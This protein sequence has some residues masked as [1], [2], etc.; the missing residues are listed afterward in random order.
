MHEREDCVM[1]EHDQLATQFEVERSRLWAVAYRM[2]GSP[3]EAEDA[4]QECWLHLIR[5]DISGVEHLSKWLTTVVARIC[6]DMLRSRAARP[7][8]SL[9]ASEHEIIETFEGSVDPEQDV[10]LADTIGLALLVVL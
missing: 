1:G 10:L 3:P 8:E 2:L 4:V 9:E 7:E 5:S 6:F